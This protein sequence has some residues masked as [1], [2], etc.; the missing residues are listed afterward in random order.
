MVLVGFQMLFG[1]NKNID[2][3]IE[4]YFNDWK[5]YIKSNKRLPKP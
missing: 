2:E 4:N 1:F 3:L 5:E